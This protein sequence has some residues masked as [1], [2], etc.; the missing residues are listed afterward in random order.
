VLTRL[1]AQ[2]RTATTAAEANGALAAHA[3]ALR[4][5]VSSVSLDE[6]MTNLIRHQQAYAASARVL[7][8]ATSLFDTLLTL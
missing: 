4:D 8:T 6:E 3:Q 7:N 5:G 2:V 1:G